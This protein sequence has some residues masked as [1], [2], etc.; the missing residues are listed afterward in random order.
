MR[1]KSLMASV[2]LAMAVATGSAHAT[3]VTIPDPSPDPFIFFGSG[4]A[5]VTYG[6]VTFSQ[7]ATLSDGNFFNI[8]PGFSGSPA[9]LSSQEQSTGVAN[10]LVTL[11]APV[12]FF[13]LHYGT[14]GGSDVN[15]TLSS[16]PVFTQASTGSGYAVPDFF[17]KSES[18]PFT[19]VLLTSIDGVLNL[20]NVS[21]GSVGATPLPSTWTMLIVGFAGVGFMAYRG[22]KRDAVAV[23]VA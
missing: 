2:A 3:T 21:F 11:P 13:S 23:A 10:I 9:V 4:D 1:A 14:F 8:G 7:S 20:N 17:S 19:S 22:T 6:G 15:F 5:S 18:T 16:G 12:T